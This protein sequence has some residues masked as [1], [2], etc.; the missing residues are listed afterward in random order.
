MIGSLSGAWNTPKG[1][2]QVQQDK[3]KL[4]E[5]KFCI[6]NLLKCDNNL[7]FK[8]CRYMGNSNLKNDVD[9]HL[10]S[11]NDCYIEQSA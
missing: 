3:Y 6:G 8:S 9:E 4:T 10:I 5:I 1:F 2:V 7:N 11:K